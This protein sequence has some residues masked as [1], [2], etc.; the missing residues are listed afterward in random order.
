MSECRSACRCGNAD[1]VCVLEDDHT[2][3]HYNKV[4]GEWSSD[5]LIY[6]PLVTNEVDQLTRESTRLRC[7][8]EAAQ[9]YVVSFVLTRSDYER[10][11]VRQWAEDKM[12]SDACAEGFRATNS[13]VVWT[14]ERL[15]PDG[16]EVMVGLLRAVQ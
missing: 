13:D 1:H 15:Y 5:P 6:H 4:C 7:I 9:D 2:D 14:A 8:I 12:V 3:L 11:S 16:P 10:L